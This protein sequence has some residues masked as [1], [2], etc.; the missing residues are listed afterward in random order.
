MRAT[1]VLLLALASL[2]VAAGPALADITVDK[3]PVH[4]C[5]A[6]VCTPCLDPVVVPEGA[7]EV[8]VRG[9]PC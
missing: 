3:L 2:T 9:A 6:G 5:V 1:L 8:V 4:A 7:V